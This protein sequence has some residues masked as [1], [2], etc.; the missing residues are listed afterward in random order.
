MLIDGMEDDVN[1]YYYYYL[2]LYIWDRMCYN[3]T[4]VELWDDYLTDKEPWLVYDNGCNE[5]VGDKIP[6][7][8]KCDLCKMMFNDGRWIDKNLALEV[9]EDKTRKNGLCQRCQQPRLFE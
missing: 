8:V 6:L 4:M 9:E 1:D 7:I 2:L 5:Q 3:G